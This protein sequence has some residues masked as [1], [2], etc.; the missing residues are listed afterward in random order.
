MGNVARVSGHPMNQGFGLAN[1]GHELQNR[2]RGWL[3]RST[4]REISGMKGRITH[5]AAMLIIAAAVMLQSGCSGSGPNTVVDTV[6]P[7][8]AVVVAGT[9]QTFTSSVTGSTTTT[10]TY[11][12]SYVYTPASTTSNPNPAQVT[13]NN[14]NSGDKMQNGTGNLG[15]WTSTPSAASNVLTYTAPTL[16]NFPN[17]I[18]TITFTA[19]PDANKSKKG[20]AVVS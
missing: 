17:P 12:C 5:T 3:T 13:V 6:T 14:C 11:T 7:T 18:P 9:V 10:S 20:T 2:G 15:T 8:A 4:T 1:Q 16:A 19:V